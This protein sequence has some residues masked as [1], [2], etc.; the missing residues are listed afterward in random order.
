MRSRLVLIV[1]GWGMLTIGGVSQQSAFTVVD[2]TI[3]EMQA[4]MAQRRTTSRAIV[5]QYSIG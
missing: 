3:A 4:A 1:L 2:A 5:Q